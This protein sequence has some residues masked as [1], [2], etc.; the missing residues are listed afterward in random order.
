VSS[1]VAYKPSAWGME[2]HALTMR[3]ALG[4]GAAGVGKTRALLADPLA[5][6]ITEHKR[7]EATQAWRE[8]RGPK[9]DDPLS[10]GHSEGWALF[11]RRELTEMLQTIA[12]SQVYFKAVDPGAKYDREHHIWT[13]S[14][15]YKYQFGHCKDALDYVKYIGNQ[16]TWIGFDEV[17][18]FSRS[19]YDEIT[20]RLRCG[21]RVLGGDP[22]DPKRYPGMLKI[23]ACTNPGQSPC[24]RPEDSATWV[25]DLFVD[26]A[27]EG[28]KVLRR[29]ITRADG[30][31]EN[32][33]RIFLPGRLSDNPNKQFKLDYE[34]TLRDKPAHIRKAYLEGDWYYV[35]G[36]F[37]GEDF[38][39][40][41]HVTRPFKLPHDW[42][43]FRSMDWGFKS[44]GVVGWYTIDGDGNLYQFEEL[45]F[46][47]LTDKR[48]AERVRDIE[49]KHG[50][51]DKKR[52]RSRITGP[53][54]TQIWVELGH[55]AERIVDV[56][57]KNGVPWEQADKS[58]GSRQEHA[59][60]VLKRL[61]SHNCGTTL[62][63]LIF[64][65]NCIKTIATVQQIRTDP[66]KPEEPLKGGDD[67]AYDQLAYGVAW[68]TRGA[69]AIVVHRDERDA[70]DEFD[71]HDKK[72]AASAGRGYGY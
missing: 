9:P 17:V 13:F 19:Q 59:S 10:W 70:F 58:P 47:G 1:E 44:P 72:A 26:P 11:L 34:V 38:D 28:R 64:T 68:A 51:W 8:N 6:I 36:T 25:R 39:K 66:N 31:K 18:Q 48:V 45:Y 52:N 62:P 61:K 43:V 56:F 21:D 5:Q 22:D 41:L 3:E 2:F 53:A 23:R 12:L 16:Y 60:K 37:F 40:A 29:T 50:L 27:P 67:H 7:C 42:P 65:A 35:P 24:Y 4:A 71:R 15:G 49:L 14:S 57:V 46:Q 69:Q 20:S 54:D 63:G 55:S 32:R 30:S 33:D